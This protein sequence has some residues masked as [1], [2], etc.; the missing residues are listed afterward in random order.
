LLRFC[1]LSGSEIIQRFN[2]F[3]WLPTDEWT[4]GV[5]EASIDILPV[6]I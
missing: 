3:V 5:D 4:M 2:C 1:D 6:A